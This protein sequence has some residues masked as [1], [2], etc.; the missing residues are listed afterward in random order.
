MTFPRLLRA[1]WFCGAI[2]IGVV[3]P[4]PSVKAELPI[5]RQPILLIQDSG[6]AERFQSFVPE[7]LLTEGLNGFQVAQLADLTASFLQ[8]YGV[9][10]LPHLVLNSSQVALLA[11]YVDAGGTLVAFQPDLQLA[12]VF[13]VLPSG[14]S[15]V[16]GWLQI[17]T[18]TAEGFGLTSQVLRFHGSAD[19]Y[20]LNGASALAFLYQDST[21]PT[22]APA[23]SVNVFGQGRAI[24]FSFDLTQSIVLLRQGNPAW[25]GYPNNHDGFSTMRASQLF[26]DVGTNTFWND[27]G[28]QALNDVPQADEQLRL[29]SN[30]VL[31]ASAAR[32]RPLPRFWYFPEQARSLLLLTGDQHGDSESN[33]SR[34]IDTVGSFGGSFTDFLWYPFGSVSSSA[35]SRWLGAGHAVGIHF[36]DTSEADGNAHDGSHPTW[37]GMTDVLTNALNSFAATYPAAPPPL[38]TRNHFLIWLSNNASGEP[39]PIA[40]AKLFEQA[41][42]ELDTSYS[43]FPNR[44]G[45][46]TGSGLPMKFLDTQSGAVVAVYE[47]ATQYED[48]VQLSGTSYSTDWNL[49]TAEAHYEKSLSD[50]LTKYNTAVTMLF[51][52][53][54]WDNY[55]THATFVLQYAQA[56]GIAMPNAAN[57]LAFWKGRAATGVAD[58]QS[59]SNILSFRLS[60]GPAGLTVL[61]PQSAGSTALSSV[62]VDGAARSFEIA[63]Y[64]G[65]RYASL[66]LSPGDHTVL[67][68]Y[69]ATDGTAAIFG[70]ISPVAA[71]ALTTVRI[72]GPAVDRSVPL[73]SDGSYTTE[74]LPAGTYTLTAFAAGYSFTPTSRTTNLGAVDVGSVNFSGTI[75]A[76]G[77]ETLFT[78]QTPALTN[79]TDGPTSEYELGTAFTAAV[80]GSIKAV[81]FWKASSES[82]SHI[83]HIW[84]S[85]G[86]LLASATF[87]NESAAGWQEQRLGTPLAIVAN[88]TYIVSVNT[89]NT[90]YVATT[91]GFASQVVNQDMRSAVGNNGVFGSEGQFPSSSYQAT[92][93]FRDVVFTPGPPLPASGQSVF[94]SQSPTL[95][96]QTD[97]AGVNYELGTSFSSDV[98]G[99]IAALRF[100]KSPSESGAH[101]GHIW[102]ADGQSLASV[103][104]VNETASGWQQQNLSAPLRIAANT[105]YIVTVNTG[106]AYYVATVQGLA[107]PTINQDL[108]SIVGNNGL[109]GPPG[110]FPTNVYQSTNY[111]RDIVFNPSQPPVSQTESLFTVQTPD[112]ANVTDGANVNYELGTSFISG[113]S[114]V[115]TAVRFWKAPNESGTHVGRLWSTTGLFLAEVTFNNE[116]SSGWQEQSLVVPLSLAANTACV[117]TV[118]TGGSFYVATNQG[119]STSVIN[120]DLHTIVGSNGLYGVPGQFPTQTYQMTNYFR[121]IVFAPSP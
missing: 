57:W 83:G 70:Q 43:T 110:Q 64:Q 42:I 15:L 13:G 75:N 36:D 120:R 80:A 115:I 116:T 39:D 69:R 82:D 33:S 63:V 35:V 19:R 62:I 48:D 113:T 24:L 3:A 65:I 97:G 114:G 10:V 87:T 41:G 7:L 81:T 68:T 20:T 76:G 103:L 67:S 37:A 5:P 1:I 105:P 98:A 108:S 22:S 40:Q 31:L 77:D 2:L 52:P 44:W 50:S 73:T 26:L 102:S 74:P 38:T 14:S 101:L 78:T 32:E 121:D 21:T 79:L 119:L 6:A 92:N 72:Q 117:V 53:D 27:A 61:I 49:A 51:H 11:T 106:N 28:D 100:W 55:N 8:H 23:A 89:G 111:F 93:Y 112:L 54:A 25:A 86:E 71:A 96:N 56:H 9:V 17:Q 34:E 107:T 109:F 47:Q 18:G 46:M 45:Y 29:F 118:N 94:I 16:E 30:A 88:T 66:V 60:G 59:A 58:F 85:N 4:S 99:Q 91:Q 90:Y 84:S 12:N 104:F 95:L